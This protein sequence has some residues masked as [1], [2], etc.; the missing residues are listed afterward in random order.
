M[1][2][3]SK[4]IASNSLWMMFEK[5]IGIFG[6]I[7]VMSY[8]AKYIGPNNFGKIALVTTIFTFVQSFVWF[9][10]QEIL[11]KRVSK[12]SYSSLKYLHATQKLRSIIFLIISL[13]VLIVLYI[14]SDMLTVVF[15]VATALSSYFLTQD[16]YNIYNNATLNSYINA[17]SNTLGLIFALLI[18]YILVINDCAYEYLAIPIVVVTLV[19]YLLKS[20]IFNKEYKVQIKSN[21]QYRKYYFF[22]GSALL[23][24]SLSI[25]FYTQITSFLLGTL[26]S[27]KALG[28]YAAALPLGISWSFINLAIITSVL[29]SIYSEKDAFKSYKM[30]FQLNLVVI[31]ISLVVA[32]VLYILGP[33]VI[34]WLYGSAYKEAQ[35][36]LVVLC[37]AAMFS[38]LGTIAARLLI[39]EESYSYISRKMLVVAVLSFPIAWLCIYYGG[40]KGAAYSMMLIEFLSATLFNYFYKNGLIFKIH[41]FPLFK[42]HLNLT[43]KIQSTS[44]V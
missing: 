13:P 17:V 1:G 26:Q 27:T 23:L 38:G 31:L 4:K 9:G 16:I 30:V 12:N 41:F 22:A 14:F 21:N 34:E 15:G 18:R 44:N 36:L 40:A 19:P 32:F 28:I 25:A 11:F 3:F 29:S 35:E 24:S 37:F 42:K 39:K 43:N 7:F 5:F 8:V 2:I 33:Y 20:F 6:L 10:N